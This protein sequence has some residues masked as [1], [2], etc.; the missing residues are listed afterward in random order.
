MLQGLKKIK[1]TLSVVLLISIL[2]T[3]SY[4]FHGPV[5]TESK[6]IELKRQSDSLFT[7][8]T[9]LRDKLKSTDVKDSLLIEVVNSKRSVIDM[10]IDK[11]LKYK[12]N[13]LELIGVRCQL[14]SLKTENKIFFKRIDQLFAENESLKNK[15][16]SVQSQLEEVKTTKTKLEKKLESVTR[17]ASEIKMT[18]VKFAA[19]MITSPLFGT[20]KK[21]ATTFASKAK[22]VEVSF[23]FP[24]NPFA[25]PSTF[26]VTATMFDTTSGKRIERKTIIEYVGKEISSVIKFDTVGIQYCKGHHKILIAI[27]D[28]VCYAGDLV[29][30]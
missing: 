26:T 7:E 25:T 18:G 17:A 4:F 24:E 27:S 19:Y 11:S 28:K 15:N 22:I 20:P 14:Q 9:N 5:E 6:K 3:A 10:L 1:Y 8:L 13:E 2:F 21:V 30:E 12:D 23:G 16:D 29:L